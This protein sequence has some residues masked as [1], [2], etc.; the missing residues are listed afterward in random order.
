[1]R[2]A[3]VKTV[4]L[5]SEDDVKLRRSL[6]EVVLM[7]G[8]KP[9]MHEC[10]VGGA[11]AFERVEAEVRSNRLFIDARTNAG[12]SICGPGPLVEEIHGM[13]KHRLSKRN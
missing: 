13:V 11:Q 6:H 4:V 8:G 1:M 12:L 5:G 9:L 10:S 3:P 2:T 7:M